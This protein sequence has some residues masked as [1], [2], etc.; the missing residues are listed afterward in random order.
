MRLSYGFGVVDDRNR[1]VVYFSFETEVDAKQARD[2]I[3]MVVA[4]AVE[5]TPH[6]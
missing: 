6:R 3:A 1:G 2:E 4:K 5:I